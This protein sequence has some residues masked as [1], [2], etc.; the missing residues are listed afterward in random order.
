MHVEGGHVCF[1]KDYSNQQRNSLPNLGET[2]AHK[3]TKKCKK[4]VRKWLALLLRWTETE[5]GEILVN[6]HHCVQ[7][8]VTD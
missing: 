7:N 6:L 4:G 5:L 2:V 8:S 1:K 3:A